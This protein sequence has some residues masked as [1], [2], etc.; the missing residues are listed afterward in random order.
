M[1]TTIPAT[2]EGETGSA[3]QG[4]AANSP[5]LQWNVGRSARPS[6]GGVAFMANAVAKTGHHW[7]HFDSG[8]RHVRRLP[9]AE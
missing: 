6:V 3:I 1:E 7:W 9:A 4:A 2:A 5:I 8:C